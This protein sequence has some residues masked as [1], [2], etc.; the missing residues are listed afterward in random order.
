[1]FLD[2]AV[3]VEAQKV[4]MD[5]IEHHVMNASHYVKDDSKELTLQNSTRGAA[6]RIEIILL[7]LTIFVIV[8]PIATS[9]S[10]S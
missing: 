9:F 2:M 1:M 7:L 8:I 6:G 5:D 3:T 4:Q 10:S